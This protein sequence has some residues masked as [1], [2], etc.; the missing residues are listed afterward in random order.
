MSETGSCHHGEWGAGWLAALAK[1][2]NICLLAKE[3]HLDIPRRRMLHTIALRWWAYIG[4]SAPFPQASVHVA[5]PETGIVREL[6]CANEAHNDSFKNVAPL[7][8][9]MRPTQPRHE[10]A[11]AATLQVASRVP[12]NEKDRTGRCTCRCSSHVYKIS[13][14]FN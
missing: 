3:T 1:S 7:K 9:H 6:D 13:A 14:E 10:L 12:V 4:K 11:L 8:G 5:S 2:N